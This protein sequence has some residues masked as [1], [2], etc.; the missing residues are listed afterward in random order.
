MVGERHGNGMARVN[1]TRLHRVNQ[2][3]KT[4]SKPLAERHGRETA[5]ERNGMY[6]LASENGRIVAGLWQGRGRFVAGSRH[7]NGIVCVNMALKLLELPLWRYCDPTQ[8]T[9]Y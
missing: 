7:G 4:Q 9:A 8:R 3:G 6:E 2:M 1:Q 5:W